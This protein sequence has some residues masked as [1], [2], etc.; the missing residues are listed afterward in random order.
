MVLILSVV[1]GADTQ[2]PLEIGR[3][4]LP[5]AIATALFAPARVSRRAAP[6]P[7][8]AGARAGGGCRALAR[9]ARHGIPGPALGRRRV[10]AALS[11]DGAGRV[12]RLPACWSAAWSS[13]RS[14][15][16][17][18]HRAQA[19]RNIVGDLTLATTRGVIRDAF[20]KVLAA[21]RPSYNVYVVPEQIDMER[22][23]PR[24]AQLMAL[25]DAGE[26]RAHR[27]TH[28]RRQSGPGQADRRSRRCS[29]WTSTATSSRR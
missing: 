18:L 17:E 26:G 24:V 19:R 5:H 10:Q 22:I 23:W 3:V 12:R 14:S 20:G 28:P 4:V 1:F 9:A 16:A 29:R 21:N 15:K 11:L 2:R 27:R 7:E 13:C 8:H 25:D 6:A